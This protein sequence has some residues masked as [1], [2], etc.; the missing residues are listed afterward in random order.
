MESNEGDLKFISISA[1][2]P[3][4]EKDTPPTPKE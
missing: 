2:D 1:A 3:G 4:S